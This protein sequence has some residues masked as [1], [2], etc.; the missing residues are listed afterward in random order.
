MDTVMDNIVRSVP[1]A[2][3]WQ[4]WAHSGRCAAA[5]KM[6]RMTTTK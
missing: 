6:Q 5:R 1:V 2:L 4:G 3:F